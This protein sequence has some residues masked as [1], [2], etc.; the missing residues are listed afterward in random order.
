MNCPGCNTK[1]VYK[2][3]ITIDGERVLV[4]HECGK[5]LPKEE[6]KEQKFPNLMM[7]SNGHSRPRTKIN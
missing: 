4:C 1:Q 2:K 5:P 7:D 6:K 3:I